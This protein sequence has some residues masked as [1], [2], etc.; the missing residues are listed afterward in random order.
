MNILVIRP[1]AIGDALLAFP[2]LHALRAKYGAKR[3]TFV[4]NASVLPLAQT[5]KLADEVSDFEQTQWS[6]LFSTTGVRDAGLCDL[7][8]ATDMAI[9]WLGDP[10]RLVEGNLR[11]GGVKK[12]IV[13]PGRPPQNSYAHIAEYLASTVKIPAKQVRSWHPA[14]PTAPGAG[15]TIAIHPGSGGERKNW[16]IASF[17]EIIKSL[18]QENYSVLVLAGPAEEQ[19]LAYL[20]RHL[21]PPQ[22]LYRTLVNAPLLEIAQQLRQCGGYLG[23]DSG[24]THLAAMLG[25]PTVAIFGPGSRVSS[26]EPLGKHVDIIQQPDLN[27]LTPFVVTAIIRAS[28]HL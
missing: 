22:G 23:N 28:F 27:L 3:I 24:I 16:P 15:R 25:V 10:E 5:W 4:S 19:K 21:T 2:T 13:A 7:L 6:E 1:G 17:V 11:R 9:C 26:W 20:Q 8:A 18:W 12:I 14:L